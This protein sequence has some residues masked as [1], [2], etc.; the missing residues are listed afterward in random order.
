MDYTLII[1]YIIGNIFE[2]LKRQLTWGI[3]EPE[4]KGFV[5]PVEPRGFCEI[6]IMWQG[7]GESEQ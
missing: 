2:D 7:H 5:G 1:T 6:W 4:P 3:C